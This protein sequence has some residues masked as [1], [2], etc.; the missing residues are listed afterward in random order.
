MDERAQSRLNALT[1]LVV[2]VS[3]TIITFGLIWL[4]S[5]MVGWLSK[6]V[7]GLS[8]IQQPGM[9]AALIFFYVIAGCVASI[10]GATAALAFL[11]YRRNIDFVLKRQFADRIYTKGYSNEL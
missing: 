2:S 5:Y 6:D 8:F 7:E 11:Y 9:T 3:L 1:M 10:S 4:M